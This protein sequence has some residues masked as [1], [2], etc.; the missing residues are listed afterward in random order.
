MTFGEHLDYLRH[1]PKGLYNYNN[2]SSLGSQQNLKNE[3]EFFIMKNY[4]I[5]TN[6]QFLKP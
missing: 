3:R 6:E 2:I 5:K 4:E 1:N